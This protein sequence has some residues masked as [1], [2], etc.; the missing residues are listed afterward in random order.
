MSTPDHLIEG[1]PE[2]SPYNDQIEGLPDFRHR[3]QPRYPGPYEYTTLAE[4]EDQDRGRTRLRG[5]HHPADRTFGE[6]HARSQYEVTLESAGTWDAAD[7][8]QRVALQELA[9]GLA[10]AIAHGQ[11]VQVTGRPAGSARATE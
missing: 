1:I 6:P 8:A 3:Y 11:A 4:I 10:V 7:P 9:A 5:L 2:D